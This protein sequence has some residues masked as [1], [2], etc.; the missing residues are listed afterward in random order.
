MLMHRIWPFVTVLLF[1]AS[2]LLGNAHAQT[3]SSQDTNAAQT[4]IR[5]QLSAFQAGEHERAFSHAAPNIRTVFETSERFVS[6]VK[7][8]YPAIY[9]PEN[10]SFGRNRMADDTI[11]QE[12]F[13]TGPK[14][15]QW[16]A[17]YTLQQQDDGSWKITGVH[18]NP[19]RG[20]AT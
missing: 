10:F 6:M 5:D 8:G 9:D 20:A 14:G 12:V 1:A 17:L 16:Q 15:Q 7:N 19:S 11:F 13:V 18:M 4:V 3:V 2:L